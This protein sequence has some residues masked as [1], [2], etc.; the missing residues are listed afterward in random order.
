MNNT[1]IGTIELP[2]TPIDFNQRGYFS[3]VCARNVNCE[4]YA[5]TSCTEKQAS[6]PKCLTA[7]TRNKLK[8]GRNR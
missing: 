7:T 1:R 5:F 6:Q 3:V 2:E 8:D 4:N